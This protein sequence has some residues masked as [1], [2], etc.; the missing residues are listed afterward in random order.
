MEEV[1]VG[2]KDPRIKVYFQEA[3]DPALCVDHPGW[4]YKG[5]AG[6]AH[7]VSK[8]PR[9][10]FSALGTIF[11]N[12]GKRYVLDAA[13]VNFLLAEAALRGWTVPKSAKEYYEDGVKL[14]WD[15]WGAEGDI[16]AYLTDDV[17][18]PVDYVDPVDDRNSYKTRMTATIK[19]NDAATNPEENLEKI[20]V[21]K[22]IAS[23]QNSIETWS[24]FRRTDY[25]KLSYVAHNESNAL[26]GIIPDGEFIKRVPFVEAERLNNAEGVKAATEKLGGGNLISTRLWIHPAALIFNFN[27]K[28]GSLRV[29]FIMFRIF[30]NF[31]H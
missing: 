16:N 17:S 6:G 13:E 29:L 22:W 8:P 25:P 9:V 21:Q 5:I 2:Y 26:W 23:F 19:W 7:L 15:Q 31:N 28:K 3:T 4:N 30:T 12:I 11:Q 27:D 18:K 14:S 1:L 24:D 10:P 20:M